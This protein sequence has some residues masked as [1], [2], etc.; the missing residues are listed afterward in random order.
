MFYS[1]VPWLCP[2]A[3]R[4]SRCVRRAQTFMWPVVWA[5][6]DEDEGETRI[7][8]PIYTQHRELCPRALHNEPPPRDQ[9]IRKMA[10]KRP[11]SQRTNDTRVIIPEEIRHIVT[12]NN[13]T[14]WKQLKIKRLGLLAHKQS[15]KLPTGVQT[16][17]E[18]ESSECQVITSGNKSAPEQRELRNSYSES[19][20]NHHWRSNSFIMYKKIHKPFCEPCVSS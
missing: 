5:C 6:E 13:E 4:C 11:K 8:Q 2:A 20:G 12:E 14:V 18:N 7:C 15:K 19:S 9:R 16:N 1:Y 17:G 3:S 10:D